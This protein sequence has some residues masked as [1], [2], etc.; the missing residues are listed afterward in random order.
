MPSAK[1]ITIVGGGLA[2]LTLAIRLRQHAIPVIVWEEGRYP[3]HRVCGEFIS[4]QGQK[5]L[6]RIGL[7]E[8]LLAAGAVPAHTARFIFEPAQS[9]L[10]QLPAPAL[11]VS[12]FTLDSFLADHFRLLGGELRASQRWP[13][14]PSGDGIVCAAGRRR[15]PVEGGWRWFGLKAHATNL[16]LNA[17]LEMHAL[18][19]GYL[20]LTRLTNGEVNVCGLFRRPAGALEPLAKS[21]PAHQ[22]GR[23]HSE[24]G[25]GLG[26]LLAM[27]RSSSNSLEERLR[28]AAFVSESFCSVAGL[29]LR[30]Q[31][32]R[33]QAECRIGDAL[34][35]IPPVTGNGMSMAFEAADLA[36]DPLAAWSRAEISWAA[37]RQAIARA[38]DQ[39]FHRRLAWA[40]WLQRLMFAPSLRRSL[41]VPLIQ[42]EW[43]WRLMFARTR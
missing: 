18:A 2:G 30:P 4:G 39:T 22:P 32:A 27:V 21:G 25:A 35:M 42:S 17:D 26:A 5:V 28:N 16:P 6:G 20:G 41:V 19:N 36:A 1:T 9:P 13:E 8:P 29:P 23:P 37:A 10:R 15:Q 11:A 43:F 33:D 7:C 31:R 3:R 34:T 38:C 14:G 40:R 24:S 12:R